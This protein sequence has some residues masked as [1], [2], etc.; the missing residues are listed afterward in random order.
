MAGSKS[1][2]RS[3]ASATPDTDKRKVTMK[4][5]G[6][7]PTGDPLTFEAI[8]YVP[9]HMLEAYVADAR[10]RWQAVIVDESGYDAGPGGADGPTEVPVHLDGKTATDFARY[11]GP[12]TPE[13]AL[14]EHLAEIQRVEA[15]ANRNG[16]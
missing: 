11:G 8:D 1:S 16:A 6:L 15:L 3:K 12:D 13:N 14:D 5:V 4:S 9:E 2:A 10:T 7:S